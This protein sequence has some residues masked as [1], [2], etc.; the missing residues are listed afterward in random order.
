M[1]V[2]QFE[3]GVPYP[4]PA[5]FE[6]PHTLRGRFGFDAIVSLDCEYTAST[7]SRVPEAHGR[8]NDLLSFQSASVVL[9]KRGEQDLYVEHFHRFDDGSRPT[10]ADLVRPVVEL[11]A[12]RVCVLWHTGLAEWAHL[13]THDDG[14]ASDKRS[15]GMGLQFVAKAPVTFE[16]F[17]IDVDGTEVKVS[18]RDTWLLAPQG[19]KAL[20]KIAATNAVWQKCDLNDLVA[21][22]GFDKVLGAG[23]KAIERMDLVL[24]HCFDAFYEYAMHDVRATLEYFL[25]FQRKAIELFDVNTSIMTVVQLAEKAYQR[26]MED[27]GGFQRLDSVLGRYRNDSGDVRLDDLRL[28]AE[29]AA[30]DAYLGGLNT[31][32]RLGYYRHFGAGTGKVILDIDM[33]GA[34][35]SAMASEDEIDWSSF[36]FVSDPDRTDAW[37]ADKVLQ[38]LTRLDYAWGS[39][40]FE[41]PDHE[42][43]PCLPVNV[44]ERGVKG[45]LYPLTG[46]TTVTALELRQAMERGC[47]LKLRHGGGFRKKTRPIFADWLA[48][49]AAERKAAKARGDK[50]ADLLYKLVGNG[51]YGKLG[52]GIKLRVTRHPGRAGRTFIPLSKVSCPQY[53]SY[54]TALVRVCLLSLV[55]ALTSLGCDV[56][57]ATTDGCMVAVPVELVD[58]TALQT[59]VEDPNKELDV[60]AVAPKVLDRVLEHWSWRRF[61]HGRQRLGQQ[62]LLVVKRWGTEALTVKTRVNALWRDNDCRG[63][64]RAEICGAEKALRSGYDEDHTNQQGHSIVGLRAEAGTG[65]GCVVH[66]QDSRRAVNAAWTGRKLYDDA[67]VDATAREMRRL[68]DVDAIEVQ[69]QRRMTGPADIFNGADFVHYY[70]S[71]TLNLDPDLK[72]LPDRVVGSRPHGD[73][74]SFL[75]LRQR[76]KQV[77]RRR[78]RATWA[79]VQAEQIRRAQKCSG[80][81]K[82]CRPRSDQRLLLAA[83]GFADGAALCAACGSRARRVAA[84]AD[85]SSGVRTVAGAAK[86]RRS[87]R[88]ASAA[89]GDAPGQG[90]LV[91]VVA[92]RAGGGSGS[93]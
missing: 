6:V 70:R 22:R 26:W 8:T 63:M 62:D 23:V 43:N 32:Y 11:G 83:L 67:T 49:V 44:D 84:Q 14:T 25:S 64:V 29:R 37:T 45:L 7:A 39:V 10:L 80:C 90:V 76:M 5:E 93:A 81:G 35:A 1:S 72:R 66:A 42:L 65:N 77:Q 3:V 30:A 61:R 56:L 28:V 38:K 71:V 31:T 50:F 36:V 4:C 88:T 12:K 53:A 34:Y 48:D 75:D 55:D 40:D 92:Q 89:H 2:T 59:Q 47:R 15:V 60:A 16:P 19:G 73:V 17:V 52:Q 68:Y 54:T 41:F 46:S 57:S 91:G 21:A 79:R 9:G 33:A 27:R 58:M 78:Q 51:F 18:A 69:N 74:R 85:A 87:R 86:R 24:R 82:G 13:S 20:K